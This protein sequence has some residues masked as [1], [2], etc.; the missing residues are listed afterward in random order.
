MSIPILQRAPRVFI[1]H[2]GEDRERFV[3]PLAKSLRL[4]RVDAWVSFWEMQLGDRLVDKV[5]EQGLSDAD[6]VVIVLS[7]I[8]LEKPWVRAE[9]EVATVRR[10]PGA[11]RVI[12][13]LLEDTQ[14]PVQLS[15]VVWHRVQVVD[16]IS[17]QQAAAAITKAVYQVSDRPPLGEAPGYVQELANASLH[18]RPGLSR[19]DSLVLSRS[20]APDPLSRGCQSGPHAI[21]VF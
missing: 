10:I 4:V 6:C 8:S 11:V 14:P 7:A 13:V 9:M 18:A 17:V 2:A 5:F 12:A 3:E 15:S 16:A 19:S 1:C 21:G 20:G